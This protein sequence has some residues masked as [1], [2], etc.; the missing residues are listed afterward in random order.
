MNAIA[1]SQGN[2]IQ[3][4]LRYLLLSFFLLAAIGLNYTRLPLF[5]SVEFIFGS[6]MAVLALLML[7]RTAAIIV[8][9]SAATVTF[10]IWGHPYALLVFSAEIAWLSWRWRPEKGLNLVQQ[11]LLFW[12]CAGVPAVSLLYAFGLSVNWQTAVL[13]A[14]KQMTNGVFNTLIASL[15]VLLLQSNKRAGRTLALPLI[16]LRQLLFHIL[17]ASTLLAGCVP[18]L[19]D[20]RRLQA[21]YQQSVQ[22]KLQLLA[23]VLHKQLKTQPGSVVGADRTALLSE[24]L[25]EDN[26]GALLFDNRGRVLARAG[27]ITSF[28]SATTIMPQAGFFH[29]QPET[30]FPLLQ[31]WRQSRYV[32]V[33]YPAELPAIGA[34]VIEQS[35]FEVMTRLEQDSARQLVLLVSFLLLVTLIA[36]WLSKVISAPLRRLALVSEQLKTD[37]AAGSATEIPSSNVAEYDSLGRSLGAMS[38][39]LTQAFNVSKANESELSRQVAERTV[40]L[41]QSNSQLEAILA[42]ASDFSIIATLPDGDI[43]YFSRGAEKLLG[44]RA[45]ELVNKETPAILHL[46]EEVEKRAE[47]LSIELNQ[48]IS[49]FQAFVAVAEREGT[50]T[51]QWHYVRKDGEKV[52]VSLTVTPILDASGTISGYLGVAK[53]ISERARNERM[54]SEFISTVSHELRTPLTSLYAALR[55]VNSGKLGELPTKVT[56]LLQV[57]ESNSQRL[58]HLINDLL[59]IEK[60]TADKFQLELK[61]QALIPLVEQAID[62]INSYAVQ[63]K[64]NLQ[65]EYPAEPVFANVDAGR[66]VQIVT[67]LLSNAIKFSAAGSLV[68][69]RLYTDSAKVH[70][71][72]T[73]QGE[74]INDD[75]KDRIFEKFAQNDAANTR[76]QGGTGLGLAISKELT[77][78]M[79]GE[80]GFNSNV[81]EGTTFWLRFARCAE[82]GFRSEAVDSASANSAESS[83]NN[84]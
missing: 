63:Y 69:V 30:V 64:I 45:E 58:S 42:A 68:N 41:Q 81:G 49:G 83:C 50:E 43:S 33:I 6:A 14:L 7:G 53:D 70:L 77:E 25:P 15:L 17:I 3:P 10:L 31:R 47:Q 84:P 62:E 73:D 16:S 32:L 56:R 24:I 34:I 67:N 27:E 35:A 4:G 12:L 44:Y 19:L 38:H 9:F 37:I 79:A 21:E 1:A 60:L 28:D 75:F 80:I 65:A 55:M 51:R 18:L 78:K 82:P 36:S 46:A 20:A 71:E 39:E 29:W 26:A 40:Q 23:N 2:T 52:P 5:F 74:G 13:I 59:D 11:D 66:F 61:Q 48:P 8:G 76:Q 22:Q 72:V 54:K 57:A